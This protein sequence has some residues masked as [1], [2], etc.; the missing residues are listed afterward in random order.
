MRRLILLNFYLTISGLT[1]SQNATVKTDS[2]FIAKHTTYSNLADALKNPDK[3][4]HL[5]LS[6][7]SLKVFPKEIF[8]FTNL[9]SLN[10]YYNALTIIPE[11]IKKLVNLKHIDFRS[12]GISELPAD[13]YSLPNLEILK[14]SSCKFKS[15]PA[16]IKNLKALRKI[17]LSRN[18]LTSLPN[19][20]AQL[21]LI[22]LDLGNLELKT[23]PDLICKITTLE[24][25]TLRTN[26][27]HDFPQCMADLVNL[28]ELHIGFNKYEFIPLTVFTL[29]ELEELDISGLPIISFSEDLKKLTKLKK[30]YLIK[31]E[32]GNNQAELVKLKE[33]FPNLEI[34]T[35]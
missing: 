11:E 18:P 10:L 1:F 28:R 15:I 16:D 22:N 34:K 29:T 3:V 21:H 9:E 6:F 17:D 24:E 5:D 25:L 31:S 26:M 23:F 8:L 13:F 14:L 27:F 20:F 33:W 7:K 4:Y 19:E 2:L 35:K 32:I 30:I 12:N